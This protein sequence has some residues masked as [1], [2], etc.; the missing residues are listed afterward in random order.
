M[1]ILTL[2]TS[3]PVTVDGQVL[4]M[5]LLGFQVGGTFTNFFSTVDGQANT[6]QLIATFGAPSPEPTP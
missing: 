2:V 4:T 3:D 1:K 6:A 5:N